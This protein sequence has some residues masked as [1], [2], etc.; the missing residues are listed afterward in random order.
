MSVWRSSAAWS[1][2]RSSRTPDSSAS[3]R[4]VRTRTSA[5]SRFSGVTRSE[6]SSAGKRGV[7]AVQ[8][9]MHDLPPEHRV[10]LGVDRLGIDHALHEPGRRA[11]G[12]TLELGR[13]EHRLARHRL[14]DGGAGE[15]RRAIEGMTGALEPSRPP[16]RR[17]ELLRPRGV[18][19]RQARQRAQTLALARRRVQR[20]GEAGQRAATSR[21]GD[22]GGRVERTD[23]VPERARLARYALVARSL[24]NENKT[25]RRSSAGGVEEIAVARDRV[26]PLEPAAELA[27][28]VVVEQRRGPVAPR[29]APLLQA[30]QE[31]HV[32]DPRASSAVIE[33]GDATALACRDRSHCGPL[34]RGDDIVRSDTPP[35]QL[36]EVRELVEGAC[37]RAVRARISARVVSHGRRIEPPCVSDHRL[38]Q[39]VRAAA[40]G[41]ASARSSTSAGTCAPRSFS[42]S[43]STRA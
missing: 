37:H 28:G 1:S 42:L 33:D 11:V 10:G 22:L 6:S 3:S 19:D 39:D 4:Q 25:A 13:R 36:R 12:E 34:E 9:R 32:E 14:Q 30:E 23:V 7:E 43:S 15:S 2:V 21:A 20:P 38:Q 5:A 40:T 27:A 24:A 41:S 26:R 29:Q 16:V 35:V 17:S 31:D 8:C 18:V